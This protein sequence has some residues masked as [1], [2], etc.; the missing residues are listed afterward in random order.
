MENSILSF[1]AYAFYAIVGVAI[2]VTLY[3]INVSRTKHRKIMSLNNAHQFPEYVLM[4]PR[5]NKKSPTIP[6]RRWIKCYKN[7]NEDYWIDAEYRGDKLITFG[8]PNNLNYLNGRELK[9]C[10]FDTYVKHQL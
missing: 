5:K 1:I 3:I 4:M 9:A 10:D 2:A 6:L 8:M 7:V